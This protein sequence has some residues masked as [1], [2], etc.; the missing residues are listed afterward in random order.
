MINEIN[1][2]IDNLI[3]KTESSEIKFSGKVFNVEVKTVTLPDGRTSFRE[4]V[5]HNGGACILPVDEEN[6]CYL[7]SQ[8]RSPFECVLLE[9][10][11]GKIEK[12]EEFIE[13]ATRELT[14]ETGY[15]ASNI[16]DLGRMVCSPG[17]CGEVIGMFLATGL[18]YVGTNLDE[19]EFVNVIKMPL[20][21]AVEKVVNNE[22]KDAKTQISILKAAR[23]LGI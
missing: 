21:E 22:I 5:N 23:R 20:V 17:Y 14:E 2:N 4:V 6:N 16:V 11:A 1:D 3:E 9:A 8:F 12:G 13:C 18:S 19:G 15:K 7:V 10:P